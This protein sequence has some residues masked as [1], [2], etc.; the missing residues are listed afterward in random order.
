MANPVVIYPSI[1]NN[2][3]RVVA[4]GTAP[5]LAAGSVATLPPGSAATVDVVGGPPEYLL[6]FGIPRGEPGAKGDEGGPG[7]TGPAG[8]G[9]ESLVFLT[10]TAA[11]NAVIPALVGAIWTQGYSAAGDKGG[12]FYKR[13]VSEPSHAAKLQS[14]DGA[15]WELVPENGGV[16]IEQFG[17]KGDGVVDNSAAFYA[18]ESYMLAKTQLTFNYYVNSRGG[19]ELRFGNGAYYFS[20]TLNV[21]RC[22]MRIKGV[23]FGTSAGLS[24][25]FLMAASKSGIILNRYDTTYNT[26]K[27]SDQWTAGTDGSIVEG[28]AFRSLGGTGDFDGLRIR[29]NRCLVRDCVFT[30]FPRDGAYI[31]ATAGS[32]GNEQGNANL[33]RLD[34]VRLADNGRDG[35][36]VKGA[37]VN[38]GVGINLDVSNN[39]GWG[40]RD[41]SFLGNTYLACHAQNN[42]LGGAYVHYAGGH[43]SVMPGKAVQASTTTPGTDETI[44]NYLGPGGEFVG[45]PNWTSGVS[46]VEGGAYC[47]LNVNAQTSFIGCYSEGGQAPS[48]LQAPATSQGGLHAAGFTNASTGVRFGGISAGFGRAF[49]AT[50]SLVSI[51]TYED[52]PLYV[53]AGSAAETGDLFTVQHDTL[54]PQISGLKL[55]GNDIVWKYGYSAGT[56]AF[57]ITGPLTVFT[58]GRDASVPNAFVTGPRFFLGSGGDARNITYGTAAPTTGYHSRGEIVF[59]NAP[60]AGAKIGWVCTTA[61]TPGT[62]KTWGAVDA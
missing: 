49:G 62:W 35:L 16:A 26:D 1:R 60:S 53:T 54:W 58:G 32:T 29:S 19:L 38:A 37:D 59:H 20:D 31:N 12:G 40:I 39:Q 61:G 43:Y 56:E 42:G 50:G 10:R 28:I 33:W 24:T 41:E 17:G 14:T 30:G 23:G 34:N 25:V 47:S 22:A 3:G 7:E 4:P 6:N 57:Y 18:A 9:S 55:N 46:T 51:R 36:Y 52:E 45:L 5:N 15:W 27:P 8:I 48:H 13:V 44:W 21:T 11:T 2:T